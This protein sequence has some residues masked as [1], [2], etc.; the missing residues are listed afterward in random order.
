MERIKFD[1]SKAL[2]FVSEREVAYFENFVRSA[3][4]MLHN[5]TGAGNDFVG[6]VDL[7]VNYDREEFARIKAAAEKIKSDSDALV[8]IGIGGSYLGARA[9]IEMLSHSF[10][11]LMPKSKRNAPEI[12]FVGNNISST[13]IADLLEV[14]EG[15]EISV[16]VISKSGTTTEPAIAF[17]IFKE[18]MENKY[19]KDGASK[20][21]YATTDKE[22]GA[23]RKLATEEGYE[24]F[25]VPDDIGGRFSV[26]TAVGLLPIAVAGIDIDSMMKG[27]ADARE[28]YSNPNLMENDCY[29]YA[30]VR[31]ALYRKNKT[32][33]IMVNYEP[34]LHYFTEWWKQLYG[35]SEG[36]DQKGI[37]PAGVDFTTDLH[38]MGQYIQDGLR[39][40]FE[41]V[42]RVEK[43]R[44]NIV[45][46]EEKDNL[47][48]LNFIAGKDVDYVNKK[49]ME[50]TVLAHTDGGVPNLVVTV[51]ELSAYYFGNMV[52]F[53]EKA[54]GISGYLLGVNPFDQPGVEAYKKN[55]FALLGKPGYEEQRKKLEERL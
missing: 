40:I 8:V 24:T 38:S 3:H 6:W 45:I 54:C 49:A 39:N 21:I 16:N 22:K 48:G 10:H 50:G 51:P 31:N 30:A 55:M 13:Y 1:Y 33:E 19:G 27:A 15:K 17:R 44:K 28:L 2:P 11:N 5:K 26:L 12:Y 43:P 53:F 18:Y 35:E 4:D 32:I 25:V 34:S 37:F 20:R 29:K 23:L 7:P 52:Y 47:D 9:A 42:I 36:K 14:I 46:K 41:T